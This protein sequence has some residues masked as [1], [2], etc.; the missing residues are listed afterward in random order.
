MQNVSLQ[1]KKQFVSTYDRAI[2]TGMQ[3]GILQGRKEGMQ[4]G[5]FNAKKEIAL[6]MFREGSS[7]EFIKK[8][9]GLSKKQLQEIKDSIKHN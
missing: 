4:E 8:V 2:A 6:S 5:L 3:K 9:T 1:A 7:D